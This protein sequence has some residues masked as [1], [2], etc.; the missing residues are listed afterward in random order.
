MWVGL[1]SIILV[2]IGGEAGWVVAETGRQPWSIQDMLPTAVSISKLNIGNVEASF[3]IFLT[4]F[5][6][7]LIAGICIMVKAIK[8]G[9]EPQSLNN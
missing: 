5:T 6:V 8:K 9:P 4:K 2:Y 3:F 7:L 1:Y